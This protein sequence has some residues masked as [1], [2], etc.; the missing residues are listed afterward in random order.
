MCQPG[1]VRG[2]ARRSLYNKDFP[3]VIEAVNSSV[4]GYIITFQNT[5][6]RKKLDDF[7]GELYQ[8]VL[9]TAEVGSVP[10]QVQA[11]QTVE[12]DMYLWNGD[13][14]AVSTGPWSLERFIE[15]RL[16]DWLDLFDGMELTGED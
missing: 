15:E 4:D 14:E 8:P 11:T 3:A 12:A 16:Q 7:E 10:G 6:Q 2:Y 1:R 9:V 5:S 13:A